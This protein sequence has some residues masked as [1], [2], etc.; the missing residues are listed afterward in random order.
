MDEMDWSLLTELLTG[1]DDS[2]LDEIDAAELHARAARAADRESHFVFRQEHLAQ[3][4]FVLL[5]HPDKSRVKV[6]DKRPR[7]GL[8]DRR[9]DIAWTRPHEEPHRRPKSS[10]RLHVGRIKGPLPAG[11][12]FAPRSGLPIS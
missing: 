9:R 8:E 4:R 1:E 7:H 10:E 3:H 5:H 6:A 12:E 2:R 11:N